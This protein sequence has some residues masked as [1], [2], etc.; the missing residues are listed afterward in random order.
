MFNRAIGGKM[1]LKQ[2]RTMLN[3]ALDGSL[4]TEKMRIDPL[5]GFEVPNHINGVD[6]KLLNPRK[7][8]AS[9]QAYDSQAQKLVALFMAN[10]AKFEGTVEPSTLKGGPNPQELSTLLQAAE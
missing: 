8:W 5:F 1:P 9:A 3:A 10:F 2:T 7:S 4:H 6:S